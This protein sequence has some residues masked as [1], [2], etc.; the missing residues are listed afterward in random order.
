MIRQ[1]FILIFPS[2]CFVWWSTLRIGY[3][4][5]IP[6]VCDLGMLGS[7][8]GTPAPDRIEIRLLVLKEKGVVE[9]LNFDVCGFGE[10]RIVPEISVAMFNQDGAKRLIKARRYTWEPGCVSY[11]EIVARPGRSWIVAFAES[12]G[13]RWRRIDRLGQIGEVSREMWS[14]MMDSLHEYY[15][16]FI[17]EWPQSPA[18]GRISGARSRQYVRWLFGKPSLNAI[19][20]IVEIDP[21]KPLKKGKRMFLGASR[22][23]AEKQASSSDD[24]SWPNAFAI[25]LAAESP[26]E[27]DP[28][29][30]EY[31]NGDYT[32]VLLGDY[33]DLSAVSL[34]PQQKILAK[35]RSVME[36]CD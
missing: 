13:R 14:S 18:V 33:F 25:H 10:K 24:H 3:S 35:G 27:A 12:K 30:G 34:G 16:N 2:L 9:S 31:T 4:M 5:A 20:T 21:Q 22:V 19:S 28:F 36:N 26:R 23:L 11:P 8:I 15:R 29:L 1:L 17:R 6:E 32:V 7:W